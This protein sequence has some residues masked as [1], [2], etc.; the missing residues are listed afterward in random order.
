[1]GSQERN[2]VVQRKEREEE[3]VG[4]MMFLLGVRRQDLLHP[5]P[6]GNYACSCP[7][8]ADVPDQTATDTPPLSKLHAVLGSCQLQSECQKVDL[9]EQRKYP[10]SATLSS[11][12][13]IIAARWR[14]TINMSS[15]STSQRTRLA[16]E[17]AHPKARGLVATKY[18]STKSRCYATCSSSSF[19]QHH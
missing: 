8:D 17:G 15:S 4:A 11:G 5:S 16:G 6:D 3:V 14:I 18:Q 10:L 9:K 7:L 1:M 13:R 2:R 12:Q 19:P